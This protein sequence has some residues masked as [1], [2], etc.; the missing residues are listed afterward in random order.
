MTRQAQH[1]DRPRRLFA[2]A[3][4]LMLA[5]LG[6]VGCSSVEASPEAGSTPASPASPSPVNFAARAKE[7]QRSLTALT[8]A[9]RTGDEEGIGGVTSTAD[10]GFA[11]D[12]R[13]FTGNVGALEKIEWTMTQRTVELS[14]ARRAALGP[15]AWVGLAQVT[16]SVPG[17][18]GSASN[19][20]WVTFQSS[21][22]RELV[23]G[24]SDGVTEARPL[25][26]LEPISV[27]TSGRATVIAGSR[28]DPKPWLEHAAQAATN[29]AGAQLGVASK[30]WNN[31]LVVVVPSNERLMER[32]LRLD[33]DEYSGIAAV[34]VPDGDGADDN[35]ALRIV[36]NPAADMDT[37]VARV[38]LTH[39]AVHVA[40]D[41]AHSAA[42]LWLVEGLADMVAND[43]YR[44]AGDAQQDEAR[45][46]L[47]KN[48]PSGLP[49][50]KDFEPTASHLDVT[51]L[52]AWLAVRH[53]RNQY[54]T[55]GLL[56]HYADADVDRAGDRIDVERL[57]RQV[58]ADLRFIASGNLVP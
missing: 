37:D 42:A 33:R 7:G 46:A 12:L 18:G 47:R 27:H 38:V 2:A 22:G 6:V 58:E 20:V 53:L 25:W 55:T 19:Q 34:T 28:V 44:W 11:S 16:W 36:V 23:A 35:R 17:D 21:A 10:S 9:A 1:Q 14:A 52:R 13:Q 45:P 29:V 30:G 31:R 26:L 24:F 56:R 51:Y 43:A 40:T 49:K 48:I 15:N 32:M 3:L 8:K 5:L 4:A 50:S 39:E 54:G 41:A 57:A